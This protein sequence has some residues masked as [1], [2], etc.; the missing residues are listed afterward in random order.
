MI[1]VRYGTQGRGINEKVPADD[2]V[3]ASA[4]MRGRN[5]NYHT[6]SPE[7]IK[8]TLRHESGFE[9]PTLAVDRDRYHYPRKCVITVEELDFDI[10]KIWE[11]SCGLCAPLLSPA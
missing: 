6:I 9:F 8:F 2:V 3:Y 5:E 7:S 4:N 11:E 1:L 10:T